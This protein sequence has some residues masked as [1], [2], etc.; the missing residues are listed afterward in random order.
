MQCQ[1]KVSAK[2]IQTQSKINTSATFEKMGV[3]S[4]HKINAKSGQSQCKANAKSQVRPGP[5]GT[6]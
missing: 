6:D 1:G 2:S 3:E 5:K 4:Q